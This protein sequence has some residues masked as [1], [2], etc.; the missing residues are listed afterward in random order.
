MC[1]VFASL[2]QFSR[3][4]TARSNLSFVFGKQAYTSADGFLLCT[5]I[6][7]SEQQKT[8]NKHQKTKKHVS[9][10]SLHSQPV[11][12]ETLSIALPTK[13]WLQL[14]SF[15]T[16]KISLITYSMVSSSLAKSPFLKDQAHPSY[17]AVTP[18]HAQQGHH[19][20]IFPHIL[21]I[22][23]HCI[24]PIST[25]LLDQVTSTAPHPPHTSPNSLLC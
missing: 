24:Q 11:Q 2:S 12:C 3:I 9:F 4:L 6:R 21:H 23:P 17:A 20:S 16:C 15:V 10:L 19:Y 8:K 13:P 7:H 1:I 25:H 5:N 22:T 14:W 18:L